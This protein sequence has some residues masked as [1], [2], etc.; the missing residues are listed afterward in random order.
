MIKD[1]TRK[2]Y[3]YKVIPREFCGIRSPESQ[4]GQGYY[5]IVKCTNTT[6]EHKKD[7]KVLFIGVN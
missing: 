6:I 3:W 5:Y 1:C 7:L 4:S 2:G